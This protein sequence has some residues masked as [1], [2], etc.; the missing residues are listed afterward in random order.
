MN[1]A[2]GR[3][4]TA[5]GVAPKYI[6]AANGFDIAG[7]VVARDP[8]F[9]LYRVAQPL[10]LGSSVQGVYGDSWMGADAAYIRYAMPG[11]RGTVR[12]TLSR[13]AWAGPDVPGHVRIEVLAL[14]G[15]KAPVTM[16]RRWV[17]HSGRARMFTL[18]TP[19]P[20]FE[21][22]VHVQPTFSPS[23]FGLPD[24]RQLGAQVAF[25]LAAR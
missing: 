17:I 20:P 22:S 13:T 1:S 3:L 25:R 16:T 24:T 12:L 21:I 23:K 8:P 9:I 11:G 4:A 6:A 15:A 5:G 2:T 10:R 7:S 14:R 18:L 19:R